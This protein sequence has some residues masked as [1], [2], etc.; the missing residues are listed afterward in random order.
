MAILFKYQTIRVIEILIE[1]LRSTKHAKLGKL[2]VQIDQKLEDISKRIVR[3]AGWVQILLSQL[4]SD[5]VGLLLAISKTD[6]FSAKNALK[7]KLRILR[8]NG[9]L[10][11]N[12]QTMSDAEEVWLTDLGK[13]F[14]K[15][16][17]DSE[18]VGIKKS[19]EKDKRTKVPPNKT[20]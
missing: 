15:I 6:K 13:D 3:Q 18:A 16:L 4:T 19:K 14:V 9:L 5:E 7:D 1:L 12:K 17:I 10:Q 20:M 8:A 11:H 2:E